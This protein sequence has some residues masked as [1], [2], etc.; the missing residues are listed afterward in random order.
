MCI[1]QNA[2][3]GRGG[4]AHR[5]PQPDDLRITLAQSLADVIGQSFD[6]I[7]ALADDDFLDDGEGHAVIDGIFDIVGFLR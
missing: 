1:I 6:Q 5:Y 4:F 3:N 7:T 2:G